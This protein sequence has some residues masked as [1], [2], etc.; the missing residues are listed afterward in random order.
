[1]DT[2]LG[3]AVEIARAAGRRTL[4]FFGRDDLHVERKANGTPVTEA[5]RAAEELLRE[6]IGRAFPDDGVVG[7]EFGTE[8][9]TS[10]RRWILDPIDGTKSFERGVPLY[11]TL[12]ALEDRGT[13]VVGV[14]HMPGLAEEVHAAAGRGATWV[15]GLGTNRERERPAQ[16]SD[17]A[18]PEAA[19]LC[20]TSPGGFAGE[21]DGGLLERLAGRV[22]LVRGWGDC[23]GHLLVATGRVEAMVDPAFEIWDAAPLKVVVEEAGGR[24][25][26]RTGRA[27]HAGGS[28]ISTNGR[29]HRLVLAE[30]A[31]SGDR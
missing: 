9:G 12:V 21:P 15:T 5:D 28:G 14:I 1:M 8:E 20:V 6:R 17:V 24:F 11:G 29:L 7:E 31:G 27:T 13:I 18:D 16:V 19:C 26:D 3:F 4:D 10:G 23:Y 25:T 2:E 30:F 22:R